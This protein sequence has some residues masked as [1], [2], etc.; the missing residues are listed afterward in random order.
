MME[1]LLGALAAPREGASGASVLLIQMAAIFAIFYFLL[2]R[3]QQK[4]AQR[5]REMVSS[6]GKGAVVV[7]NGG[8][9]GTVVEVREDRL[10][11]ESAGTPLE[12]ER[13]LIARVTDGTERSAA[14][15]RTKEESRSEE[16]RSGGRGG[17]SSGRGGRR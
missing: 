11:I 14:P 8:I 2:I 7:T 10:I 16:S 9:V 13:S 15:A 4:Q 3:P 6:V 5:H 17:R 12:V 1:L